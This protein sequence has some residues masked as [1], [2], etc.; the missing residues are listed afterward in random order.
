MS[1]SLSKP[2]RA[3]N[4]R[5]VRGAR[6]RGWHVVQVD[7]NRLEDKTSWLGLCIWCDISLPGYWVGSFFR[8]EFAFEKGSDATAFQ[9]K[10]G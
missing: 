3:S 9:L 10:W 6:K 4:P 1:R 7:L 5:S 2:Y 8:R